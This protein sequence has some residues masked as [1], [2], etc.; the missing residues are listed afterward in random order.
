MRITETVDMIVRRGGLEGQYSIANAYTLE[1][2]PTALQL[3]SRPGII[4]RIVILPPEQGRK[5]G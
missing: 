2:K 3:H 1:G 4:A 5:S